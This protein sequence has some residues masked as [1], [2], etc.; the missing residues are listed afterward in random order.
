MLKADLYSGPGVIVQGERKTSVTCRYEVTQVDSNV[1][2]HGEFAARV[3][4]EPEPGEAQL[5][6][7]GK[8]GEIV[9]VATGA[10]T[11]RGRFEG[12]GPPPS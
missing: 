3:G 9:L 1:E 12:S 8:S 7:A 10:G 2:W 6:A 11:G 5:Y 4:E